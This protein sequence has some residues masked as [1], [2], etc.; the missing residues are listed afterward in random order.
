MSAD[1][2]RS[3]GVLGADLRSNGVLGADTSYTVVLGS[4]QGFDQDLS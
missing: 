2:Q 1:D 4:F 3:N